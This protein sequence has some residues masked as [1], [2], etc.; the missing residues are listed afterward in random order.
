MRSNYDIL[1][2][3]IRLV[4]NRNREM[5]SRNVLG[6]NID[7]YFMP[8][9]ANVIGTDLSKYKLI[10]KGLF[11][12]NP[13][14]VGRDERLP[15]ALYT[16]DT[17]AIV[18]PA[19]FM[20]EVI[21]NGVLDDEYLML[22]FL[23]SEFDRICWLKTDGSVRGGIT[24]EDICRIELP[25]PPLSKQKEIVR[26]YKAIT[27]R[28]ALKQR[29]N[30]NLEATIEAMFRNYY[31]DISEDNCILLQELCELTS[32]KR[33]FADDYKDNGI[34]FYRGSE[35]TLKHLGKP[36]ISP[37]YISCEHYNALRKEYGVPQNGDILITAVGTIGN[38][39][40]VQ[41]ED[42]Y[43]K[44][45]NIIWLRNFSKPNINYYIY[46]FMKSTVF[47]KILDGIC[48][49]STQTALTIVSLSNVNVKIPD[50]EKLSYYTKRS[51]QI[52]LKINDNIKEIEQ[53]QRI[54]S[55]L[56]SVLSR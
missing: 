23:R 6:I 47:N 37:L 36:I 39:Y 11:A 45:G 35:I 9:V 22:W 50:N 27:D 31:S 33:V 2:N 21:D 56:L 14:H 46:D 44:D 52:H 29:I 4:D 43:F 25:I 54:Q 53:L 3:Q 26:S 13:M 15:V 7:K 32:S 5:I 48:I 8:S 55:V 12:C 41:N 42:F 24:W 38:S 16:A 19:Y 28:I 1:G 34:P 30:D 10:T 40:M 17:P 20:F 51:K 18:S 49:G